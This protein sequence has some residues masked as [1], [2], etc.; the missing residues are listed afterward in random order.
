MT[1][2]PLYDMR[3]F[4]CVNSRDTDHPRPSCSQRGAVDLQGYFAAQVQQSPD[5]LG[6]IRVNTSGC[7]NRCE[8]GPTLV[9]YPQGV[10]YCYRTQADLDEILQSHVIGGVLVQRLLLTTTA[11][12]FPQEAQQGP[13]AKKGRQPPKRRRSRRH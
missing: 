2:E 1:E 3:I 12:T 5:V 10:W 4:C 9:I 13:A 11:P 6:R 8:L 7:L